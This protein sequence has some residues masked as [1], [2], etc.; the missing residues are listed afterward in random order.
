MPH[1]V[2]RGQVCAR[3]AGRGALT[4]FY[5]GDR[6]RWPGA[7]AGERGPPRVC[8]GVV[9]GCNIFLSVEGRRGVGLVLGL[10]FG[11]RPGPS[12]SKFPSPR[13]VDAL[14]PG[15]PRCP[16]ARPDARTY[17]P[18][19]WAQV[20]SI[21]CASRGG[22]LGKVQTREGR[23]TQGGGGCFPGN[24]RDR[25]GRTV[26]RRRVCGRVWSGQAGD[27]VSEFERPSLFPTCR[28]LALTTAPPTLPSTS[29][30]MLT[31]R[32]V[33]RLSRRALN[34]AKRTNAFFSTAVAA[35]AIARAASAPSSSQRTAV[36]RYA[37]ASQ[38]G[39]SI[40]PPALLFVS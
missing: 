26:G 36:P 9:V 1:T 18:I 25:G 24:M 11:P 40:S 20:A 12:Q 32:G 29:S 27:G 19:R 38:S 7:G 34:S 33:H 23:C 22:E 13:P 16:G 17:R 8:G 30:R 2:I 28:L 15:V 35:P 3:Q 4:G 5:F 39:Q 21:L 10:A 37:P 14:V 31:S 6:G